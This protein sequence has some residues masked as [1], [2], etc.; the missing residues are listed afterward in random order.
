MKAN[1]FY[2]ALVVLLFLVPVSGYAGDLAALCT[3]TDSLLSIGNIGEAKKVI[4]T[5]YAA[6][7]KNYEVLWRLS[8]VTLLDGDSR[9]KEEQEGLYTKS[10]AY[11]DEAIK[12][13]AKG[14][15]G[16]IR[17]AAASGK[18]ALFKGIAGAGSLVKSVRSDTQKAIELNNAGNEALALA[19]YIL[20]RAHLSLSE[21]PVVM[22]MAIGLDWGNIG[23]AKKNL[24]RAV[25]LNSGI[26]MYRYEYARSLAADEKYGEARTEL[27]KIAAMTPVEIGDKESQSAAA[28]FLS[29][30]KS[31]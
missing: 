29:S 11:A 25:D 10:Q 26:V 27:E 15:F 4:E 16:Y 6:D 24:K 3:R 23:D 1:F 14:M 18:I 19:H 2:G 20:G 9:L 28:E 12:V 17:R 7:A 31:K 5:A 22:R 13:N 21:K 8:R 30:I